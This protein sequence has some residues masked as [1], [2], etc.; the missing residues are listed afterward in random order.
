[1]I[2]TTSIDLSNYVTKTGDDVTL[3]YN[4]FTVGSFSG[5]KQGGIQVGYFKDTET[6]GA[7]DYRT[8]TI[9]AHQFNTN[10]GV[11]IYDVVTPTSNDMAANKKYVDDQVSSSGAYII[12]YG[13][14]VNFSEVYAAYT[15]GRVLLVKSSDD[16]DYY[17]DIVTDIYND[18][19]NSD[20]E[21]ICANNV[22]LRNI[23]GVYSIEFDLI[24]WDS[25]DGWSHDH[26][27]MNLPTNVSDLVNDA[28]YV[29]SSDLPTKTSDLTNDSGFI[30]SSDIP[31]KIWYG[32]CTD[33]A[34][35]IVKRVTCSGFTFTNGDIIYVE[36]TQ[37][38]S[39]ASGPYNWALNVNNTGTK[40][41]SSPSAD[42]TCTSNSVLAFLCYSGGYV[43]VGKSHYEIPDSTSD[44]TNDSGFITSA[45]IP[46]T[47]VQDSG[48]N[49]LVSN[50]IATIPDETFFVTYDSSA[51]P[52]IDKTYEEIAEAVQANKVCYLIVSATRLPLY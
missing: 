35:T 51:T 45:D 49:S 29:T 39:Y 32:T 23:S 34:N 30:T 22:G 41:I 50:G 18:S 38:F 16:P 44:L 21:V 43:Y 1:M 28:G 40:N 27:S 14:S 25:T 10:G 26:D 2:G 36:F 37:G 31:K 19:T 7:R 33:E 42:L 3:T 17:Y 4:T 20:Y 46:V 11:K 47:D 5:T 24:K 48:G 12:Q 6:A 15:A 9:K 13:D 52:Q 8:V